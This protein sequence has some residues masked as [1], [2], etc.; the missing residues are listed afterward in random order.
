M[1]ISIIGLNQSGKT[2]LFNALS[3]VGKTTEGI[4]TV[5]VPDERID[6]LSQIFHPKKT[7]YTTI[8]F[9]DTQIE[10]DNNGSFSS[11]TIGEI[12][13]ADAL[14][15]IIRSFKND[16]VSH[17][18]GSID[19]LRDFKEIIDELIITDLMQI[20]KRLERLKKESKQNSSEYRVLEKLKDYLDNE[21]PLNKI[22]IT[23][24]DKKLISG[25][26]FLTLKPFIA[27][28]NLD[29]NNSIDYKALVNHLDENKY[30]YLT[31]YAKIEEEISQLEKEDQAAFLEDI[32]VSQS[33]IDR[34]IM[35]F[36]EALNLIS[37]LTA[38]E[39]EVKAWTIKKGSTAVEAARKIH[40]DIARGFIRAEVVHYDDFIREGSFK[41]CRDKGLLRLEGK[42]YIVIDGD[43]IN[44]RFNI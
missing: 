15:I 9:K 28:I 20:E 37:F 17:P 38:G 4:V 43:I 35:K 30:D 18:T 3:G 11:K 25:F 19:P 29:E 12:R 32:G 36:Y 44:F 41:A 22:E 34:L 33:I 14:C 10:L 5:K 23:Q 40:S 7:T 2:T 8:E 26:K 13:N 24:E 1:Q 6:K 42:D 31:V 27:I 16:T 39:D 21:K